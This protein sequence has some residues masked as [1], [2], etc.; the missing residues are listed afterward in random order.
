MITSFE[1]TLQHQQLT[2][3]RFDELL[4]VTEL[5][6]PGDITMPTKRIALKWFYMTFHKSE[7]DQFVTLGQ[8]LVNETFESVTEYFES[9]YN[10][11]R[12]PAN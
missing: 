12:A 6:P 11:K 2:S 7:H 9:L 10:I 1:R 8:R 3:H 5:L 4:R